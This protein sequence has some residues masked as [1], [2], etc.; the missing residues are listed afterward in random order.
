MA[1]FVDRAVLKVK[2]G[3]GG[4]GCVSVLREKFR[5]LGGP[6]GGNGGRGGSIILRADEQEGSLLTYHYQPNQSRGVWGHAARQKR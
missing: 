5:P 3:D 2:A 6:D 1:E 4:N